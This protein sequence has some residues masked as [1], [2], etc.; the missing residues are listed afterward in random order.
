LIDINAYNKKDESFKMGK[1]EKWNIEA[2]GSFAKSL[3][4]LGNAYRCL[5]KWRYMRREPASICVSDIS[6]I[7]GC[8]LRVEEECRDPDGVEIGRWEHLRKAAPRQWSGAGLE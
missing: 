5:P 2:L 8:G 7:V 6:G 1:I 4:T 3:V